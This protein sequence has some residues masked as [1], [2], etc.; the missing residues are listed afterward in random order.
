MDIYK[1]ALDSISAHV[2][3]LDKSGLILETNR[4]W[5][6]FGLANGIKIEPS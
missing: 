2:A 5:R 3:I 4:A 1:V 6:D